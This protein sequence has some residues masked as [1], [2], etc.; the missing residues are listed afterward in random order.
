MRKTIRAVFCML[1]AVC[2]LVCCALPAVAYT[3]HWE[4]PEVDRS[5]G[6][7]FIMKYNGVYY[8][9][10]SAYVASSKDLVNWEF[11]TDLEN[12]MTTYAPEFYYRDGLFY[13]IGAPRGEGHYIYVSESPTGPFVEA[14]ENLGMKFD[15]TMMM[16]AEN[17]LYMVV[18]S[19]AC[20]TGYYMKDWKTMDFDKG[21]YI[22]SPNVGNAWTEGPTLFE[23]NGYYYLTY[24]GNHVWDEAYRVEYAISKDITTGWNE[25]TDNM[26]LLDIEGDIT[27]MGHNSIFIGPDLDTYYITY[28]SMTGLTKPTAPIRDF[29][30][31]RIVWNGEKLV[32]Q[33]PTCTEVDDPVMPDFADWFEGDL[34]RWDA[35]GSWTVKDAA[36]TVSGAGLL[37]SK[38]ATEAVFTAEYNLTTDGSAE[39]LFNYADDQNYGRVWYDAASKQLK[40]ELI[41]DGKSVW[42]DSSALYDYFK[43]DKLHNLRIQQTADSLHIVLDSV[44]RMQ[45]AH[46]GLAGGKIG[47]R[48][49]SGNTAASFTAFSHKALGSADGEHSAVVPGT[50]EAIHTQDT[51]ASL[52][53]V[54]AAGDEMGYAVALKANDRATYNMQVISADTYTL[55]LRCRSV[56]ADTKVNILVDGKKAMEVTLPAVSG[57]AYRTLLLRGLELP[58]GHRTVSVEVTSGSLELYEL[59]L[60]AEDD[61]LPVS[62]SCDTAK[63]DDGAVFWKQYETMPTWS[64]GTLNFTDANR[65]GK[66]LVGSLGYS[67]YTQSVDMVFKSGSSAGILCRV[68]QADTGYMPGTTSYNRLYHRGYYVGVN[69]SVITLEKHSFGNTTTLASH[70]TLILGNETHNL[71]VSCIG[72]TITVWLDGEE[73]IRFT[74][75]DYPIINGRGG[76]RY[77][78]ANVSFDNYKLETADPMVAVTA[79]EVDYTTPA[80]IGNTTHQSQQGTVGGDGPSGN[81]DGEGEGDPSK[82]PIGIV[83]GIV[84]GVVSVAAIVIV[85]VVLGKKKKP[86]TNPENSDESVGD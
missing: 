43:Y 27:G 51:A 62:S 37:L 83:L 84:G 39:Y 66:L 26:L 6:D 17:Q 45:Y 69:S 35:T 7:P 77:D 47:Y 60:V 50:I 34:A 78:R 4:L 36:A 53:K 52:T 71:K 21:S 41:K 64:G 1:L 29:N 75:T 10:T 80:L 76:I 11:E 54:E 14:S 56:A 24:T 55:G 48:A 67:D 22:L 58:N 3:N 20:L 19:P 15:G 86:A 38:E 68:D 59:E 25:P 42:S 63:G 8:L 85:V 70:D 61:V 32:V 9:Y 81:G 12:M 72:D 49:V 73:I 65:F 57:D 30:Y 33:G 74:D 31:D 28:H 18:P 40:A 46:N 82:F 23:R 44:D 13:A 79:H 5:L 2:L 16:D